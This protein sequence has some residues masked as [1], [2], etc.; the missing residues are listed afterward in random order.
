MGLFRD[1]YKQGI[2]N[3]GKENNMMQGQQQEPTREIVPIVVPEAKMQE[4]NLRD[5][6]ELVF[7]GIPSESIRS[8]L[9]ENG[10]RWNRKTK[11]WYKRRDEET[12]AWARAF[13][14]EA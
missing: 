3:Q 13:V 2:T 7:P 8:T 12:L 9:K 4:N 11:V 5:G 1:H 10:W 6:V 14:G